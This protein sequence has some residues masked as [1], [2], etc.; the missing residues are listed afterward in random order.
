L[1][2]TEKNKELMTK[3]KRINTKKEINKLIN[4]FNSEINERKREKLMEKIG[5]FG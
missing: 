1:L 3:T 4:Q 2:L 5:E